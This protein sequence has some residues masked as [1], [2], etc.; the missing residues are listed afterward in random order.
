M[1]LQESIWKSLN[2]SSSLS[3]NDVINDY[4]SQLYN[5]T[6]GNYIEYNDD[7]SLQENIEENLDVLLDY[8]LSSNLSVSALNKFFSLRE[9]VFSL[10]DMLVLLDLGDFGLS[11]VDE[12]S[13]VDWVKLSSYAKK[14]SSDFIL[15][16]SYSGIFLCIGDTF[17]NV[18]NINKFLN[19]SNDFVSVINDFIG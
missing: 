19:L 6:L 12:I 16:D 11:N 2:E 15:V 5:N 3:V 13:D 9:K 1:R 18:L 10:D 8:G 14:I 7:L 4:I 17:L